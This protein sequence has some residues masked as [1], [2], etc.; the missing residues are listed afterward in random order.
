LKAESN[1]SNQAEGSK[2][3][4]KPPAAGPL[5]FELGPLSLT[6]LNFELKGDPQFQGFGGET[7]STQM[8][9]KLRA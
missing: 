1:R 8:N 2:L 3:K 4:A 7:T 5:S 6:A 9:P